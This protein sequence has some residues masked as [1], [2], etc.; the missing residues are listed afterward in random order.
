MRLTILLTLLISINAPAANDL[1]RLDP[2]QIKCT[3]D[4]S[5]TE[6]TISLGNSVSD[7]HESCGFFPG[8]CKLLYRRC[9]FVTKAAKGLKKPVFFKYTTGEVFMDESASDSKWVQLDP[10]QISCKLER[11]YRIVNDNAIYSKGAVRIEVADSY[12][13]ERCDFSESCEDTYKQCAAVTASAKSLT[14]QPIFF[15]FKTGEVRLS[16]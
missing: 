11:P 8:D 3:L 2:S 9:A 14:K 7:Y 4:R 16:H 13:Y 6:V 5:P 10:S 12:F 15:N 1:V